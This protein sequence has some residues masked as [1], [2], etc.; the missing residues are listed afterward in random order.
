MS[1]TKND[2]FMQQT[3]YT[4]VP[5][6]EKFCLFEWFENKCR[7]LL[8]FLIK[9]IILTSVRIYNE[10]K[11]GGA[12]QNDLLRELLNEVFEDLE[13]KIES[14]KRENENLTKSLNNLKRK[15]NESNLKASRL[16]AS[17]GSALNVRWGDDTFYNTN[18]ITKDIN[19]LQHII[20]EFTQVDSTDKINNDSANKLLSKFKCKVDKDIKEEDLRSLLSSVLQRVA[21]EIIFDAEKELKRLKCLERC[22]LYHTNK[23][24]HHTT[25]IFKTSIIDNVTSVALTRIRQQCY[26]TLVSQGF[27]K[28]D[29][30]FIK[31]LAGKLLSEMAKHRKVSDAKAKESEAINLIRFAI[32]LRFSLNVKEPIPIIKWYNHGD[33]IEA[34]FMEGPWEKRDAYNLMVERCDFPVIF[35]GDGQIFSKATVVVCNANF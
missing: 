7:D 3:N 6:E 20:Y 13:K 11:L 22:I 29:H 35:N 32:K 15:L 21:L 18:K 25:D 4:K 5:L 24:V 33:S 28:P 31:R 14:F 19:Q 30:P 34:H 9:W 27:E 23:L 17:L 2:N 26:A 8:N 12:S 10:Y 16:Q 1:A